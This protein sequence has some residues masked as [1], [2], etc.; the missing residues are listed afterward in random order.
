MEVLQL[1]AAPDPADPYSRA[2]PAASGSSDSK[3]FPFGIPTEPL[4]F[5]G[6]EQ[7]AAL[8]AATIDR[9]RTLGG[10]S[11]DIDFSPFSQ[12]ASLLYQG[13]WIAERLA[14]LRNYG[15]ERWDAMD[16]TVAKIIRAAETIDGATTF[17]GLH[18]LERL[19]RAAE[20]VW[21]TIDVLVLPT[22]G[23][24]YP[25]AAV[26]AD[27]IALNSNLGRYTNF[28]NF[29]GLSAIAVP[30]GFRTN[31]LPYSVTLI[32]RPFA[33]ASL[34]ALARQ[35]HETLTDATVGATGRPLPR[36]PV[37]PLS[38]STG[39]VLAVV[40]AHLEGQPLNGQLTSRGAR[41]L[42]TTR[43]AKGY[44][45][46]ALAGTV[47]AKPGLVR[48]SGHQGL[49]ELELWELSEA[50]FGNLVAEVPPPLAIGTIEL[51]DGRQVKGF[52]CE[53]AAIDGAR[54]ITE[55]RGWRNWLAHEDASQA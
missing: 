55:F 43:T 37:P 35:L 12:T 36:V 22:T 10:R 52:I 2:A 45:L 48:K 21:S 32:G 19:R 44:Q 4:E 13:P 14:A 27:P 31:G 40:G 3:G 49:I 34:A 47:P 42:E 54:D 46:L 6:D 17:A 8:H 16:P 11:V 51:D 9:L 1:A 50:A 26:Q 23:T 53:P 24:I 15:F 5:F 38:R 29:L 25:I 41:K 33:E 18:E 7:A 20:A 30:A 39:I 28:V